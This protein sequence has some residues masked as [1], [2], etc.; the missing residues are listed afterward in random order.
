MSI[1]S[2]LLSVT[3][4]KKTIVKP[5]YSS[6]YLPVELKATPAKILKELMD[7]SDQLIL[8]EDLVDRVWDGH[9][10]FNQKSCRLIDVNLVSIRSFIEDCEIDYEIVK[11]GSGKYIYFKTLQN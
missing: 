2:R 3:D 11:C 6:K 10:E 4:G 7:S 8:M 9:K 5:D 1:E